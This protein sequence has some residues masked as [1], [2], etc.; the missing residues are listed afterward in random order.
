MAMNSMK[1]LCITT[2]RLR[3]IS[4]LATKPFKIHPYFDL[5]KQGCPWLGDVK[6]I[7]LDCI[8]TEQDSI[9]REAQA[10]G[11]PELSDEQF[12]Y[13]HFVF[14]RDHDMLIA[15]WRILKYFIRIFRLKIYYDMIG[16]WKFT[17][18]DVEMYNY[19]NTI[20]V[21]DK[22][23]C[24]PRYLKFKTDDTE[25]NLRLDYPSLPTSMFVDG[26]CKYQVLLKEPNY[27][28]TG[29]I[30]LFEYE[31]W[32][33]QSMVQ[34]VRMEQKW[35]NDNFFTTTH[36]HTHHVHFSNDYEVFAIRQWE[37]VKQ[38]EASH[39]EQKEAAQ[40]D[41][42]NKCS[43]SAELCSAIDTLLDAE[44][45]AAMLF[46]KVYQS[47]PPNHKAMLDEEGVDY[48]FNQLL[49]QIRY[50]KATLEQGGTNGYSPEVQDRHI[51]CRP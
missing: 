26:H 13:E 34:N 38:H 18:N 11:Q 21:T 51:V 32:L 24:M 16:E 40:I 10:D 49:Q 27:Y 48:A 17:T 45:K 29:Y 9:T 19:F 42:Y 28:P 4:M 43:N 33:L 12:L 47:C 46:S 36:L 35:K 6:A 2:L 37:P 22:T 3:H 15:N 8:K 5:M 41:L 7:V 23:K 50:M 44:H 39:L 14:N 1:T 30:N 20:T 31:C 25:D